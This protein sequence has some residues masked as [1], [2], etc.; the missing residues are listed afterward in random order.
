MALSVSVALMVARLISSEPVTISLPA[1]SDDLTM[2]DSSSIFLQCK[3][4]E[5]IDL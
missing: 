1:D 2:L 3:P 4:R 5:L